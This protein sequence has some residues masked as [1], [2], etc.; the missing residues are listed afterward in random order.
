[1]AKNRT[2][3]TV[4][5]DNRVFER[6]KYALEEDF[7]KAILANS[8][9]IF[10]KNFLVN[11]K[12]KLKT[13]SIFQTDVKADLLMVDYEYKRWWVVEVERVKRTG[14][15]T[16]H[17]LPQLEK[18]THIDYMGQKKQ[19]FTS[20]V[21]SFEESGQKYDTKKLRD[22]ILFNQPEFLVIVNDYPPEEEIWI[23]SLYNCSLLVI[24]IFRDEFLNYIYLKDP[25]S[26][27]RDVN[28]VVKQTDFDNNLLIKNPS[29]IFD[30]ND[31]FFEAIV[32]SKKN[33]LINRPLKFLIDTN[34]RNIIRLSTKLKKGKYEVI[35]KNKRI[36]LIDYK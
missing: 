33:N 35:M 26:K 25:R 18:I 24:N 30:H 22:L 16:D 12:L 20:I 36:T 21:N 6:V 23:K 14:W 3:N 34:K 29:H 4:T 2:L 9:K 28:T 31:S 7:E 32:S 10:N 19:I 13:G 15:L 17:V 8:N 11:F 1:M 27:P 5:I